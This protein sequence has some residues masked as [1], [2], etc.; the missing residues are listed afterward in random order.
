LLRTPEPKDKSSELLT[1]FLSRPVLPASSNINNETNKERLLGPYLQT[2]SVT[3]FYGEQTIGKT[4]FSQTLTN[5][6]QQ[7]TST[8]KSWR[9]IEPSNGYYY[10]YN[11]TQIRSN[12]QDYFD[13]LSVI[14]EKIFRKKLKEKYNPHLLTFRPLQNL[15]LKKLAKDLWGNCTVHKRKFIILDDIFQAQHSLHEQIL[16]L[17]EL[18]SSGWCV[19]IISNSPSNIRDMAGIDNVFQLTAMKP[20]ATWKLKLKAR[21]KYSTIVPRKKR[22]NITCEFDLHSE[23]PTCK[24]IL[25]RRKIT[26]EER[27]EMK[28]FIEEVAQ[29]IN[30]LPNE[31][32][33]KARKTASDQAISNRLEISVAMVRKLRKELG[34]RKNK[35]RFVK[36]DHERYTMPQ[37]LLSSSCRGEYS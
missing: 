31:K 5:V 37:D 22:K 27:E 10:F 7:G 13:K 34:W 32:L 23:Q 29:Q 33:T 19:I 25:K 1:T 8:F 14:T 26:E 21:V 6:M 4:I 24:Q 12:P 36:I 3:V 17:Q 35:N 18:K 20:S 15:S 16:F 11:G 9:I 30:A 28:R 2:G